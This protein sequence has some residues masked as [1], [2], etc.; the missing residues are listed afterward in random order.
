MMRK[1]FLLLCFFF[2]SFATWA[3]RN[4]GD[5]IVPSLIPYFSFAYQ[6]PGGDVAVQF[7]QNSTI[8]GGLFY[9]TDKNW[10]WS[11]DVNFI[12]GNQVKNAESIL[13]MVQTHAGYIIDGN[14]TYALYALYERGYSLNVRVGKVFPVLD[15]TPNSGLMTL[16]GAGYLIHRLNIDNQHHTAP[17]I[18][19][20]YAKGY[21][22]LTGG[23]TLNEFVG[24]FFMGK[25]RIW[26]FY[27]GVELYQAFTRSRRDYV[28]DLM[29]KDNNKYIDLFF[30]LKIGWMIPVYRR[31]PDKY[32]YY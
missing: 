31:A 3:Q 12:F 15:A 21:D 20:D 8:G 29:K 10:L 9:K 27:G 24:Y 16:L 25:S 17:Q 18:S 14:G 22:R 2:F 23:L 4:A 1:T 5:T 32:Y 30:G 28:F 6:F 19:Y 13:R 7:G 26:N 11:G